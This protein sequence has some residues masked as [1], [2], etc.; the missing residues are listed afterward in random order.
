[1]FNKKLSCLALCSLFLLQPQARAFSWSNA[2][3]TVMTSAHWVMV[4]IPLYNWLKDQA[5][6]YK[7]AL[8]YPDASLAISDHVKGVLRKHNCSADLIDNLQIKIGTCFRAQHIL[9]GKHIIT[10]PKDFEENFKGKLAVEAAIR[11]E[12][13]HLEHKDLLRM[14]AVLVA[15]TIGAHYLVGGITYPISY[16]LQPYTP[17]ALTALM[18]VPVGFAKMMTI[19]LTQLVFAKYKEYSADKKS[20]EAIKDPAVLK[21]MSEVGL[22][23]YEEYE[24]SQQLDPKERGTWHRFFLDEMRNP[25]MYH[26]NYLLRSQIFAD[27][28][29]KLEQVSKEEVA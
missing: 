4:G 26:H 15:A 2:F 16:V 23:V 8:Q 7:V 21:A 14:G 20:A 17:A 12:A 6:G 3:G 10:V 28:A 11:H 1:M 27:A 9:N 25:D 19:S 29:K 24:R 13:A 5:W 22:N 18:K